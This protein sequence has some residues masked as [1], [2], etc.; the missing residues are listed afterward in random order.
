MVL[1]SS[2]PVK[3]LKEARD[4]QRSITGFNKASGFIAISKNISIKN[5]QLLLQSVILTATYSK[6]KFNK[7]RN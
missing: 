3:A 4:L 5:A 2:N 6:N 1:A 7:Q